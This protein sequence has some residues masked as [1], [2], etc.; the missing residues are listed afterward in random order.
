MMYQKLKKCLE[1]VRKKTDFQPETGLVLGSGLGD[2][3]DGIEIRDVVE[4]S[5]IEGFPVSTVKG[6]KGRFVFGYVDSVPVVIMQGRVH[7]YEG[8][9]MSDVVLPA[10]LMGMMGAKRLFLTNA[11]GGVNENFR[12]GDFMMITDHIASAVPSPLIGANIEELGSRF[13]DMSE[14]YSLRLQE[15]IR[16]SA[17]EC[18]IRLQEGV[19]VQLTGPNY[20]TPAEIRMC[21]GWGGDAV[22]MSPACE[23][24]AARHMGLEVCGISCITNL[25]AGISSE[26]LDHKEVQE[27]ADRVSADFKKLV[28]RVIINM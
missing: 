20:E 19:Y 27:T 24:M 26:K 8:Y 12:P 6:H 18:G 21:R 3:A 15:V 22:G 2:F 25:A 9:A 10:R 17:E 11:A 1:S 7:Y 14:V 23:A 28:T 4:Y 5:D 13:P 16:R